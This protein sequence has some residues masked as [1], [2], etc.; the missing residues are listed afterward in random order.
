MSFPSG[1]ENGFFINAV[2]FAECAF[3]GRQSDD[4]F[5]RITDSYLAFWNPENF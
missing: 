3:L 5:P 4:I 1:F 2:F